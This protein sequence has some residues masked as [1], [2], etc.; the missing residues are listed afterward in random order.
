LDLTTRE[1]DKSIAFEE[2]KDTLAQQIRHNAD[3][4]SEIEAIP[5]VYA[6]I[7]VGFVI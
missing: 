3:V 4:V 5:K 7:P 2:V 6:L 1:R